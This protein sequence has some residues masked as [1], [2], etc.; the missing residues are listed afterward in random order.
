ML[1]GLSHR[2]YE[3]PSL[4]IPSEWKNKPASSALTNPVIPQKWWEVFHDGNLS[5]LE[6]MATEHNQDLAIAM[7]NVDKARAL[8]RVEKAGLFPTLDVNPSV[9]RSRVSETTVNSASF[10]SKPSNTFKVPLDLSYEI[11]IWGKVRRAFAAGRAD[12][13]ASA[14][15]YQTVL[16]TLT[17]DVAKTYFMI[18]ALDTE[19]DALVGAVKLRQRAVDML[20]LRYQ[21]GISSEL[22]LYQAQTQLSQ[23][24]ADLVDAKRRRENLVNALAVLCGQ[25]A[26]DFTLAHNPLKTSVPMVPAGIPSEI[27]KTRPD[28]IEAEKLMAAAHDRVGVAHASFFPSVTLTGS[29][30]YTSAE[31]DDLFLWGSREW[32]LG[33]SVNIP[34]FNAGRLT[35]EL[36]AQKAEY[37]KTLAEYRKR[38]LTAFSE[39]ENSLVDIK[40]RKE[41]SAA[42]L[43]LL[44]AAAQAAEISIRRYE[45]GLVSFLEVIDSERSRL[46]AERD[47]IDVRSEELIAVARLIKALGGSW[48]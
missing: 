40:L 37:Q 14:A 8:A 11:D 5:S 44:N 18:G 30:G 21:K 33:P 13:Q 1:D 2:S 27:L 22:T 12:A 29:G 17:V 46:Q 28:I 25:T 9:E 26:G 4:N 15:A 31:S 19:I 42:H 16:L 47:A 41:Q 7:A 10:T 20:N 34:L 35:A 38:V 3:T 39:V 45:E 43:N 24:R 32:S 48:R 36:N 23:A 6:D